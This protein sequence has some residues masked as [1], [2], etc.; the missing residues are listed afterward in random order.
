MNGYGDES[1]W[2]ELGE[3]GWIPMPDGTYVNIKTR[4]MMDED[5]DVFSLEDDDLNSIE[6]PP[7][8]DS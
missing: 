6:F 2:M 8:E 1:D 4:E 5:G 3:S 7:K